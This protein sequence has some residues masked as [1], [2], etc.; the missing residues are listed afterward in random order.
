MLK[1]KECL[2]RVDSKN[3]GVRASMELTTLELEKR[4][5]K[6]LRPLARKLEEIKGDVV[7]KR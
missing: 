7:I 3:E 2:E 5:R 6:S 4:Q 1:S